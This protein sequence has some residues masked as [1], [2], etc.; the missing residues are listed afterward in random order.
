MMD[1]IVGNGDAQ[2]DPARYLWNGYVLRHIRDEA[3][4]N[5]TVLLFKPT[6]TLVAPI[7]LSKAQL[8]TY[9]LV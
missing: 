8:D 9:P 1:Y 3:E 6:G 7:W 2:S 5:V 4:Y